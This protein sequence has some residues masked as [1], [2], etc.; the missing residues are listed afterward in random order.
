MVVK[1]AASS[2]RLIFSSVPCVQPR[3]LIPASLT[4]QVEVKAASLNSGDVFILDAGR[5][6][7]QWNG[8]TASNVER[9]KAMEVTKQ[10]RDQVPAGRGALSTVPAGKGNLRHS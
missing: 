8:K 6:I 5:A 1:M 10:I 4:R 3:T 7:F 2:H 9:I